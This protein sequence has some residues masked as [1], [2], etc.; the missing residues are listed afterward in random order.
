LKINQNSKLSLDT[1][2][3]DMLASL[4]STFPVAC[5]S[6]EFYYF[7]QV[8]IPEVDWRVWDD[9]SSDKIAHVVH[10]LSQWENNLDQLSTAELD[11]QTQIDIDILI[12]LTQTLREQ[13]LEVRTWESQPTFYL[14]IA[15]IGM[16]EAMGSNES[17]AKHLRAKN[18]PHFLDQAAL[19]LKSVPAIFRDLAFEMLF[20]TKVF[21]KSLEKV[22]PELGDAFPALDRF[23]KI[24][25][26]AS[27]RHDFFHS[28]DLI[29]RIVSS[30]LQ[31][32]MDLKDLENMLDQEIEEMKTN[33]MKEM[34]S[35][36]G[37]QLDQV[38]FNQLLSDMLYRIPGP[39]MEKVDL[40]EV[41]RVEVTNLARHCVRQGL[42]SSKSLKATPIRVAPMPFYL[43][44]IRAAS[45]YSISPR[46]H[47]Q[48]GT[49]YILNTNLSKLEQQSAHREYSL[50]SA[51]ETYPGHHVL[52]TSR[53]HLAR[54]LRRHIESPLFYE[55]W[56]CFAEELMRLTGY[57]NTPTDRFLL[58]KRR[59]W[60][61]I[62]GKVDLGLQTG[63]LD[64]SGAARYLEE[65]GHNFEWA[66]VK[67][68]LQALQEVV[69]EEKGKSLAIRSEC[70]GT[71]GKVFQTVGVALPP[72]VREL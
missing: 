17:E 36:A 13:L 24:L 20:D 43:S 33:L 66:E 9:F 34:T 5:A 10:Q 31:I 3:V 72:T 58:Y 39:A 49:F 42:I 62:R 1:L 2:A 25:Q 47:D 15:L 7:P 38:P 54:S 68:D 71:C 16:V 22:V 26:T 61:A 51:H 21:L 50:L 18:L 28:P 64:I 11:L 63:S 27:I 19:N 55:G 69:I 57:I 41:Y 23:E 67:Q 8:Q 40:I 4:A 44:A 59:L 32:E 29:K 35:L 48:G 12:K 52:D 60:R 6:D 46:F 37:N 70:L 53:W 30:H 65:A 56:A 45:S 14:T